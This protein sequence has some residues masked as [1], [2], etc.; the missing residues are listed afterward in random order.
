MMMGEA[1]AIPA[2]ASARLLHSLSDIQAIYRSFD[3]RLHH[4]DVET[5]TRPVSTARV[6]DA[7]GPFSRSGRF[8]L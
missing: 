3:P 4:I 1:L 6:P 5:L 7:V 8:V 2:P